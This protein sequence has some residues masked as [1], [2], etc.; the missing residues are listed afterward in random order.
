MP[1][2]FRRRPVVAVL[3]LPFCH[4]QCG[5]LRH[6]RICTMPIAEPKAEADPMT[7]V[8]ADALAEH[9]QRTVDLVARAWERRNRQFIVLI[10]VLAAAVLVAFSRQLI[11]PLLEA[12]IVGS[13]KK[14]NERRRK[15]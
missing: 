7:A 6:D 8:R 3:R 9:Y 1:H 13:R 10:A 4:A 12:L 2:V 11:A 5:R 14:R 15:P